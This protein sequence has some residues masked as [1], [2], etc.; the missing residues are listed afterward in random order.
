M[1]DF[2]IRLSNDDLIFSAAHFITFEHG[3]SE[4]LHGHDFR[5]TLEVPGPLNSQQYVVDFTIVH[6]IVKKLLSELDHRVLLPREH[7]CLR[8]QVAGEELEATVD[9]RRWVFPKEHCLLLPLA[10]TTTEMLARY[11][12]ERI[13]RALQEKNISLPKGIRVE[14][15]EGRGFTAICE[16]Q[17]AE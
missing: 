17:N 8:I 16:Y 1:S 5:L 15:G 10:N 14:L 2:I 9:R 3:S 6:E 11:L 13:Y 12:A 7:P 4:A